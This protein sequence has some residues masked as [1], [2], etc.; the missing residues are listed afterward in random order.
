MWWLKDAM[1]RSV[2]KHQVTQ[3]KGLSSENWQK[4]FITKLR[5]K[6]M[7]TQLSSS[8]SEFNWKQ[9][10]LYQFVDMYTKSRLQ[11]S[12]ETVQQVKKVKT[13]FAV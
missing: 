10:G 2:F 12:S 9:S 13:T 3:E 5:Q 1:L 11:P 6:S 7:T 4:Y 8:Q